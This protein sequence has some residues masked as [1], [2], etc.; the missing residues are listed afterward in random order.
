MVCSLCANDACEGG[1]SGW[2]GEEVLRPASPIFKT[3]SVEGGGSVSTTER[4][5]TEEDLSNGQQEA[6]EEHVYGEF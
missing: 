5:E 1:W 2:V 3:S 6:E 4:T